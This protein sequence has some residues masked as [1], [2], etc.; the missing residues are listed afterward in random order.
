M[1][2]RVDIKACLGVKQ[3][4][5][6]KRK[7]T[8]PLKVHRVDIFYVEKH[9]KRNAFKNFFGFVRKTS[10]KLR[11]L[12]RI[13]IFFFDVHQPFYIASQPLA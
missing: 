9:Q 1:K 11:K 5:G 2:E 10:V 7:F 6:G 4:V 3:A 8:P 12:T 13:L